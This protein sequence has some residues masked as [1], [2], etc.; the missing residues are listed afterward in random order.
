MR[1][2]V[3]GGFWMPLQQGFSVFP[4][5]IPVPGMASTQSL[6]DSDVISISKKLTTLEMKELNERQRAEHANNMYEQQKMTLRSLE[7]RNFELEQKFAEVR[8]GDRN[9][10]DILV[11]YI[12]TCICF[13]C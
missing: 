12:Y 13:S 2:R 7:D 10:K 6:R 8:S 4:H 3:A 9:L 11:L 5:Y 1:V